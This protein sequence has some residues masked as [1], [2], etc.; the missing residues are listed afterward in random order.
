[1]PFL[2]IRAAPATS[3]TTALSLTENPISEAGN[4]ING[5]ADAVI[6]N[7]VRTV[8]GIACATSF[9]NPSGPFDDSICIL[10]PD[11][12]AIPANQTVTVVVF[13][14]GG[15]TP[16]ANH[17][18][19][20]FLRG[21]F[22]PSHISGYEVNLSLTGQYGFIMLWKGTGNT[23]LTNFQ[24]L[25]AISH[26]NLA[27][28]DIIEASIIGTVIT[29]RHNPGTGFVTLGTYDTVNDFSLYG[30]IWSTGNPGMDFWVESGGTLTSAGITSFIVS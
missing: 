17:E 15:Y 3:Y 9:N 20:I 16:S 1:M 24:Q 11:K 21:K 10:N 25:T 26:P 4:W 6:N 8:S 7:D 2:V 28:G 19:N 5:K 22:T 23:S 30:F 13:R 14:A 18:I 27:D 29:V 12:F